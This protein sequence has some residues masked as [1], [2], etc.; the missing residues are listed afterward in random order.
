M[1]S[2]RPP[3]RARTKPGKRRPHRSTRGPVV[4]PRQAEAGSTAP[5]SGSDELIG[6]HEPSPST[7]RVEASKQELDRVNRRLRDKVAELERTEESL[8]ATLDAVAAARDRVGSVLGS[9]AD[10]YVAY[11]E[12]WRFVEVNAVAEREAFGRPAAEL[13]GR[14]VWDLFPQTVGGD[15]YQELRRAVEEGLPVHFESRSRIR[16]KWW[17]IHACPRSTGLARIE[18]YMRDITA[19][20]RAE[21]QIRQLAQF[22]G[23]NPNPVLRVGL[24]GGLV[25]ANSPGREML[26]AL[27]GP[28]RPVRGDGPPGFDASRPST[29]EA[30]DPGGIVSRADPDRPLPG[31]VLALVA[32][33]ASFGRDRETEVSDRRGRTFWLCATR[34]AE[35]PYVNVYARDITEHRRAD[36]ER[37]MTVEFL[38]LVNSAQTTTELVQVA[39]AFF[40]QRSGAEATGIR[41]ER[42]GDCP[43][44]EAR[45]FPEAFSSTADSLWT[46]DPAG[47]LLRDSTGN[48]VLDC[49]C[50]NVIHG[51]FDPAWPFVTARGS[52]WTNGL[53]G[54][55]ADLPAG[56]LRAF[57]RHHCSGSGFE[58]VALIPLFIGA[59]RLGLLQI[60]D[61]RPGLFTPASIAL[62]E[63]LASHVS[64][65][66]GRSRA[67][68]ALAATR[69]GLERAVAERTRELMQLNL[70]LREEAL[71][72][73]RAEERA[74]AERQR[75]NDVL[76]AL[77]AYV[78][79]LTRDYRVPFAN[80]FF[81]E[82]FGESHGRRCYEYL[83]DRTGPCENCHSLEPLET[84]R[85][86]H[87]EWLG[88]DGRNY[89]IHDYPFAD[90]DGSTMV[91]EIP[92]EPGHRADARARFHGRGS[93]PAVGADRHVRAARHR[94][95][96]AAVRPVAD[97]PDPPRRDPLRVGGPGPP[98][99]PRL[100]T[101]VPLRRH[102]G[103]RR[104][105]AP[106]GGR[107]QHHRHHGPEA[108]PG[109]APAGRGAG[110]GGSRG[111]APVQ[112]GAGAVR[113]RLEPRPPGAAPDG[114]RVHGPDQGT[115]R[116]P[117]RCQGRSLDRPR[118]RGRPA[119][120][121]PDHGP[122]RVLPGGPAGSSAV[123]G[124][125]G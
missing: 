9:I 23:Q 48:P 121:E 93:A 117:D 73:R 97:L 53:T 98:P 96:G 41:L 109:D 25:Y 111:A 101:G 39:V 59:Q 115:L 89:D 6:A 38:E 66:L 60:N 27:G 85:P 21:Q 70:A 8:R 123:A 56:D 76:E 36:R 88:P 125:P 17:E 20:R 104:R 112:R 86:T 110:R 80:R 61:R 13:I 11:D 99:R 34:P 4:R 55:L 2:R 47:E 62:W 44:R 79:L 31:P 12:E 81:R 108:G 32:D 107:R 46:R 103:P 75:F 102:P 52:F 54:L 120:V 122:A 16:D 69:Q 33:V 3:A 40:R 72:R 82:R 114:D 77:P 1:T 63:R 45:G 24:D 30:G 50:G 28:G 100:A 113:L 22:P 7:G 37:E 42:D 5:R 90:T 71:E 65:A 57:T 15:V 29:G 35:E 67:E 95:D 74:G 84:L 92:L 94:R 10:A 124:S 119:D 19:R 43:Y 118:R 105:R 83:F 14:V 91:L 51:R 87:W 78:V 116:G 106:S 64:V 49:M 68:E 26:E 58:S 18:V